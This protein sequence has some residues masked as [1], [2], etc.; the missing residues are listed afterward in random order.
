MIA[1]RGA[2][3][4]EPQPPIRIEALL[5]RWAQVTRPASVVSGGPQMP[6]STVAL[7][8]P[9]AHSDRPKGLCERRN[10]VLRT[11]LD[12]PLEPI[13]PARAIPPIGRCVNGSA[14]G[15]SSPSNTIMPACVDMRIVLGDPIHLYLWAMSFRTVDFSIVPFPRP[16]MTGWN[17]SKSGGTRAAHLLLLD[18]L[19]ESARQHKVPQAGAGRLIS[20]PS[21]E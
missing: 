7:T 3:R 18:R 19:W 2:K 20:R 5:P 8:S 13:P 10:V 12:Y 21:L 15:S 11:T 4:K 14:V 1:D 17:E 9:W 6:P 16:G